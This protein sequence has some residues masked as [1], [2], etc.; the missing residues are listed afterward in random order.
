MGELLVGGKEGGFEGPW[1]AAPLPPTPAPA[2]TSPRDRDA[3]GPAFP[4]GWLKPLLKVLTS[5]VQPAWVQPPDL[6]VGGVLETLTSLLKPWR[7]TSGLR[8]AWLVLLLTLG[9]GRPPWLPRLKEALG[10]HTSQERWSLGD[11][12]PPETPLRWLSVTLMD[13]ISSRGSTNEPP[14]E[15][16]RCVW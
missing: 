8:S 15:T 9:W 2:N 6:S 13:E 10:T 5:R 7:P 16:G 3:S 14:V 12:R 1:G 4:W 11:R